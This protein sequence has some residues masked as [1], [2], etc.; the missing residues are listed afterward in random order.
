MGTGPLGRAVKDHDLNARIRAKIDSGLPPTVDGP[1][2][3]LYA[4]HIRRI[5]GRTLD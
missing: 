2:A 3:V 4:G 5:V 1:V